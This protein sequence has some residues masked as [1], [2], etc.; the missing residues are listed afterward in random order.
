[1]ERSRRDAGSFPLSWRNYINRL[2]FLFII[3]LCMCHGVFS[4]VNIPW[5]RSE[6]LNPGNDLYFEHSSSRSFLEF[7]LNKAL[8]IYQRKQS[9]NTIHRCAFHT[10][11]S[12]FLPKAVER[13]G[14]PL[15]VV[16]FLDRYLIRENKSAYF[17]YNLKIRPD[18]VFRLDD[19]LFLE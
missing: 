6:I 18:G 14:F 1:M 10:S 17:H 5:E 12:K 7:L 9:E 11:C 4:D 3:T 16:A 13:Y 8:D 15:G 2:I 19:D